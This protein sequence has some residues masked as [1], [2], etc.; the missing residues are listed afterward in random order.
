[1]G[2]EALKELRQLGARKLPLERTR[3]AVRE[4]FIEAETL[5]HL[6][7]TAKVVGCQHLALYDREVDFDLVEPTGMDRSMH[8]NEICVGH[9][10]PVDRCWATVRR[11][12]IHHPKNPLRGLLGLLFHHLRD[13]APEWLDA[14]RRF[15]PA[16]DN[17]TLPS[18]A[19][20]HPGRTRTRSAAP[21][22]EPVAGWE[23]IAS[24]P[25]YWSFH[26]R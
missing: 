8:D 23:S 1:M 18:T 11:A 5:C 22:R 26:Q 13:Q 20:H 6:F 15:T 7:K 3:L 9:G 2:V 14:C 17:P 10:Q 25:E 19:A 24:A 16:H 21:V 4:Y 12:V